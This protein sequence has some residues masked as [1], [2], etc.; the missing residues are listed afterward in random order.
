MKKRNGYF[1]SPIIEFL[2]E[3]SNQ[4]ST[5]GIAVGVREKNNSSCPVREKVF[6]HKSKRKS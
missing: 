5:N 3:G 2:G 6:R 4:R 1:V